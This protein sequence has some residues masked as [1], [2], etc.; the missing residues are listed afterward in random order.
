MSNFELLNDTLARIVGVSAV[1]NHFALVRNKEAP[2]TELAVSI[3]YIVTKDG[4]RHI[5]ANVEPK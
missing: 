5:V 3:T 2:Q 1:S 4:H